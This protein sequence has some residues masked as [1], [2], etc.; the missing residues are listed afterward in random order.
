MC[1]SDKIV[2]SVIQAGMYVHIPT[3]EQYFVVLGNFLCVIISLGG[4][5]Y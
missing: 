5:I 4:V 2:V 1:S 3:I